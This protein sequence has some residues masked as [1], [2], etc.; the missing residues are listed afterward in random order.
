MTTFRI[1]YPQ[2]P[3]LG[4][5]VQSSDSSSGPRFK[6]V[7][8][9]NPNGELGTGWRSVNANDEVITGSG[10]YSWKGLIDGYGELVDVTPARTYELPECPPAGT[11]LQGYDKQHEDAITFE[12]RLDTARTGSYLYAEGIPLN[13]EVAL[14]DF[15]PLTEIR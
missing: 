1:S 12:V 10:I 6:H 8:V 5:I 13:W 7:K 15:G 2:E 9:H 11:R 3:A 14:R 4:T